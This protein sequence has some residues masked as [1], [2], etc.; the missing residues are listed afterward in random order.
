MT[1]A[2]ALTTASAF[3]NPLHAT[4]K[5]EYSVFSRKPGGTWR[6]VNDYASPD[7]TC[8]DLDD[9]IWRADAERSHSV[10][11]AERLERSIRVDETPQTRALLQAAC[12]DARGTEW[13]VFARTTSPYSRVD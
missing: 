11:G 7:L 3:H 9:A 6:P 10:A 8:S 2:A 4:E 12:D 13:A 1:S 5:T